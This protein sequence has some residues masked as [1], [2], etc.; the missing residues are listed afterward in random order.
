MD[1]GK[2][3]KRVQELADLIITNMG[4]NAEL[5]IQ[6]CAEMTACGTKLQDKKLLAF[7]CYYLGQ[8][9]YC[10]ND[11][12]SFFEC[13]SRCISYL[14]KDP[15]HFLLAKAYNSLGIMSANQGNLP[16]AMDYYNK[17][18]ESCKM[19]PSLAITECGII[20][21]VGAL[22][23]NVQRYQEAYSNLQRAYDFVQ[24]HKN[25]PDYH[26]YSIIILVN[27][28]KCYL[29]QE[30]YGMMQGLFDILEEDH[31]KYADSV[32]KISVWCIKAMYYHR[33]NMVEER[34]E[35]IRLIEENSTADIA[36]MDIFDDYYDYFLML[37]ETDNDDAFWHLIDTVEPLIKVS[38]T[39]NLQQK[40]I[41]LKVKY[42]RNHSKNAEYLQST[43]L[44]YELSV[45]KEQENK[46]MMNIML[47]MQRDLELAEQKQKEMERENQKLLA[48]SELDAL[49]MLPNRY[50]LDR[51]SEEALDSAISNHHSISVEIM[52]IDYFKELNDNYGHQ[53]GDKALVALANVL[54]DVTEQYHGFCARYG[55]DEF[56]VI[57]EDLTKVEAEE[58]S[59]T[60]KE[61]V[62]SLRIE[63]KYSKALPI[64]TVSQGVSYG[65][66]E[67]GQKIT[68]YLRAADEFLYEV[69]RHS[70]NN[71]CVKA[72]NDA[73]ENENVEE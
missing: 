17:G 14:L 34:N 68:D 65:I 15:D 54:K 73:K 27:L 16:I 26:P 43:G 56:V 29:F 21:N 10:L 53:Y 46:S 22:Y 40:I 57:F 51:Y 30:K 71:Y 52:D 44:Y 9:Y 23:I 19:D 66:P 70:R 35:I 72:L 69:K 37:L 2:Y 58:R 5:T 8:T 36:I 39:I 24:K 4:V 18:L 61:R 13:T 48:K 60:I 42:Y 63:H 41:S 6:Y 67:E 20:C 38:N 1:F 47:S 64:M 33:L 12:T 32:D 28:A 31:W 55:G 7:S 59:R 50:R 45:L 11:S 25:S 3:D 62:M 49:T